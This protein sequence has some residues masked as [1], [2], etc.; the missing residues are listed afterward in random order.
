MKRRILK[1]IKILT[2][3]ILLNIGVLC[4][5][6]VY[7]VSE[8]KLAPAQTVMAEIHSDRDEDTIEVSMLGKS[9]VFDY[10]FIDSENVRVLLLGLGE[11]GVLAVLGAVCY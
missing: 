2:A 8:N 10:S 11:P 6:E 1:M 3:Y 7:C 5:A 9:V 4:W